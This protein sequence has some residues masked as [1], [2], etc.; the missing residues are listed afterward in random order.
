MEVPARLYP[1]PEKEL[2]FRKVMKRRDC[3]AFVIAA[4]L[5][6]LACTVDDDLAASISVVPMF[7]EAA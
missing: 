2:A 3:T 1:I 7:M 6:Y 5:L 4:A